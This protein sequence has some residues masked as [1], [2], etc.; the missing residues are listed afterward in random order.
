MFG[1][2][3]P[4]LAVESVS[5][6]TAQLASFASIL[7]DKRVDTLRAFLHEYNSPLENDAVS[8]VREADANAI[9]WKLVAAIAG[10]ESTFGKH[11]PYG[12]Y[13]AWG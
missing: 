10:T 8:F 12:S 2:T 3:K 4:V 7:V 1:F 11:I 13:N 6:Q 5:E 9:D